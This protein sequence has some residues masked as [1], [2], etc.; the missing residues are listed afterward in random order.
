MTKSFIWTLGVLVLVGTASWSLYGWINLNV[1][2]LLLSFGIENE[3]TQ[4][5]IT[6][7]GIILI[8]GIG[9]FGIKKSL[10]KVLGG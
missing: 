10:N 3:K 2:D 7:L 5:G 9:V 6:F 1:S 4:Y 8:L